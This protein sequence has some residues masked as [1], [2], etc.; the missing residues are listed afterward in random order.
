MA[1]D[2]SWQTYY[3]VLVALGFFAVASMFVFGLE[4]RFDRPAAYIDGQLVAF[5]AYG[6][7]KVVS[8]AEAKEMHQVHHTNTDER[9]TIWQKLNPFPAPVSNPVKAYI[10]EWVSLGFAVA[11]PGVLWACGMQSIALAIIIVISLSLPTVVQRDYNWPAQNV[12]LINLSVALGPLFAIPY[13]MLA[14]KVVVNRARKRDG[15]HSPEDRV[16]ALGHLKR[17]LLKLQGAQMFMMIFP[18]V[19]TGL[20]N[21]LYGYLAQKTNK[22]HWFVLLFLYA[23]VYFGFVTVAIGLISLCVQPSHP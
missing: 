16:S 21:V 15:K 4:T 9:F 20:C 22:P 14:D 13:G 2:V 5:D 10:S 6:N 23:V 12:G 8:D 1:V 18:I 3:F 11:D 19:V 7:M 17:L